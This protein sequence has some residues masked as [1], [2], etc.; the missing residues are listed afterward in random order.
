MYIGL[1]L[2]IRACIDLVVSLFILHSTALDGLPGHIKKKPV[3]LLLNPN[4]KSQTLLKGSK[5]PI[6]R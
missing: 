5:Y 2:N 6:I 3:P 4:S 1:L